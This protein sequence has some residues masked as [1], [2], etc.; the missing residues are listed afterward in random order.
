MNHARYRFFARQRKHNV[1]V[2]DLRLFADLDLNLVH[3]GVGPE[4]FANSD[5]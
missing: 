4:L 2:Q 3:S 5:F 1:V